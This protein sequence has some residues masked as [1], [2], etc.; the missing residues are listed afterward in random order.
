VGEGLNEQPAAYTPA[1]GGFLERNPHL[2]DN[3]LALC[4]ELGETPGEVPEEVGC[5]GRERP[6]EHVFDYFRRLHGLA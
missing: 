6:P 3:Y 4:A 2:I 5:I 1:P